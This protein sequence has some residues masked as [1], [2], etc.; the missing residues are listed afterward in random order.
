MRNVANA[1]V[2]DNGT[3]IIDKTLIA[4][5]IPPRLTLLKSAFAKQRTNYPETNTCRK[6]PVR[7]PSHFSLC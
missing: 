1:L 4:G 6:M 2:R 3:S 7:Y 5:R